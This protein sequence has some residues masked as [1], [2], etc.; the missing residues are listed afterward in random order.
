MITN[1]MKDI[2][3]IYGSINEAIF[4]KTEAPEEQQ[5]NAVQNYFYVSISDNSV[6]KTKYHK[7]DA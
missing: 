5:K 3:R 4:K 2:W 7:P 1:V 6:A